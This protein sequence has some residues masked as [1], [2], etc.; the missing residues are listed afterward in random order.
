MTLSATLY[1]ATAKAPFYFT[2]ILA[3]VLND[4]VAF[5]TGRV[6][7]ERG[8]MDFVRGITGGCFQCVDAEGAGTLFAAAGRR[9]NS[10]RP[11]SWA[12]VRMN[13][14]PAVSTSS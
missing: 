13:S 8:G 1:C 9:A 7:G 12:M 3:K 4:E 6:N 14:N 11:N 2:P 5:F 10:V